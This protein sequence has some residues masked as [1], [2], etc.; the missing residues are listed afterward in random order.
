MAR[1]MV[2]D[3]LEDVTVLLRRI[4]ADRGDEIFCFTEE[5]EAIAFVAS[6]AVDL[7]IVDIKLKKMSGIEVLKELKAIRPQIR[8]MLLTGYP[9]LGTAR[10]AV[11]LGADE[12]CVKPFGRD[13]LEQKVATILDSA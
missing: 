13:E 4:L 1:I 12:Y 8:V 7:A 2:L 6:T 3:D 9:T 5:E 11:R 10:E